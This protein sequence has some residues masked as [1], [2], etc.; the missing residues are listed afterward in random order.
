M[1]HTG[2]SGATGVGDDTPSPTFPKTSKKTYIQYVIT[3][4]GPN[5]FSRTGAHTHV[6]P[7]LRITYHFLYTMGLECSKSAPKSVDV[8]IE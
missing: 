2:A 6:V 3:L 5:F 7:P 8:Y 4:W 1:S